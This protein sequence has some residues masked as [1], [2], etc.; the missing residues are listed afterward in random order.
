MRTCKYDRTK[1]SGRPAI[2]SVHQRRN[3]R[4]AMMSLKFHIMTGI[5]KNEIKFT[6][7]LGRMHFVQVQRY[8]TK[9]VARD[10]TG[11]VINCGGPH[12]DSRFGSTMGQHTDGRYLA[13]IG[14][15]SAGEQHKQTCDQQQHDSTELHRQV[16]NRLKGV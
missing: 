7:F 15:E 3:T 1:Q 8:Q 6:P 2:S 16:L 12:T 5:G 11:Q 10:L 14:H 4:Y 13:G 9:I